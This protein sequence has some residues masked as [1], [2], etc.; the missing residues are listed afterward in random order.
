MGGGKKHSQKVMFE[1][2]K[3]EYIDYIFL[4][5]VM[6]NMSEFDICNEIQLDHDVSA[7]PNKTILTRIIKNGLLKKDR[8]VAI[9]STV[10]GRKFSSEEVF[11]K[12]AKGIQFLE[13]KKDLLQFYEFASPYANIIEYQKMK[14]R[15]KNNSK[16]EA[17]MIPL[18]SHKLDRS[19]RSDEYIKVKNLYFDI[20]ELYEASSYHSRAMYNY[21]ASLY[22]DVSGLEYYDVFL[23]YIRGSISYRTIRQ[24]YSGIFLS[25]QTIYHIKTLK[26]YY[27][28]D[29]VEHVYQTNPVNINFCT[30]NRFKKLVL[31]IVDGTFSYCEWQ[32]Y[33]KNAFIN[34]IQ[35]SEKYKRR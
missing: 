19:R 7:S 31:D 6:D 16:F 9:T 5:R 21:I 4:S 17:V 32:E 1:T 8:S 26:N 34:M 25:P 18:L 13:E 28:N 20:G 11:S 23:N 2:W 29:M 35:V 12:T 3:N 27:R 15:V 33:F 10:K 22:F 24:A 14:R 30:K